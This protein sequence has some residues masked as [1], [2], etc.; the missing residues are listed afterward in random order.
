MVC[1]QAEAGTVVAIYSLNHKSVGRATHAPGT[2][3]AHVQYIMRPRAASEIIAHQMPDR[4]GPAMSWMDEQEQASRKNARVIDKV[5]VALPR[6][7][8]AVQ[9]AELIREF[10]QAVTGN[11]TPWV[12]AM[13][14]MGKDAQNP[15]A[16]FIFRDRDI[17]SGK[18]VLRLSDSARDREKAG[19]EPNGT[20]WLRQVW[21]LKAN[22]ALERAGHDTRIDRRSLEAQGI[23]R[24]PGVHIGPKANELER[25]NKVPPSQVRHDENGRE[26]RWPEID[27]GKSRVR[28]NQEIR[29]RNDIRLREDNANDNFKKEIG[30]AWDVIKRRQAKEAREATDRLKEADR[31]E[32]DALSKRQ[33]Q[34][35]AEEH[36]AD[37]RRRPKGLRGMFLRIVGK[38]AKI[39]AELARA[40]RRRM[41]R[42]QH[43][44][45]KLEERQSTQRQRQ[46]TDLKRR[47]EQEK[48][49]F[50]VEAKRIHEQM[51]T[52]P[53]QGRSI[54][55]PHDREKPPPEQRED[56]DERARGEGRGH[57]L[58]R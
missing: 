18:R 42:D 27:G 7:L 5:M 28:H 13:H 49:L 25:E 16:H 52:E 12:A 31:R 47:F 34:R 20:A 43:E 33:A 10:G 8:D 29:T 54:D 53:T 37:E 24:E 57:N 56:D 3:S 15:H 11:R 9:R 23:D 55:R 45:E 4:M 17:E 22:Q 46:E 30:R 6:E 1:C 44:W 36:A 32:R 2:A 48:L 35:A 58:G 21:E 38:K 26:I 39:E 50:R 51:Q 14:D 41:D 19:L 40:K